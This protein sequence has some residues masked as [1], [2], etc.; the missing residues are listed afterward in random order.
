MGIHSI[1]VSCG[2]VAWSSQAVDGVD[3]CKTVNKWFIYNVLYKLCIYN[4]TDIYIK[5]IYTRG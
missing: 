2:C 4:V 1:E 3:V 5:H